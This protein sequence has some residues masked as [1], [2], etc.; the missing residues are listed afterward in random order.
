MTVNNAGSGTVSIRGGAVSSAFGD[1]VYNNQSG[2]VTITGGNITA[3]AGSG[4]AIYN[5]TANT[6]LGGTPNIR[7]RIGVN[8]GTLNVITTGADLFAPNEYDIFMLSFENLTRNMIV[9]R[10]GI[11]FLSNFELYGREDAILTVIDSNIVM[12]NE[13]T[14]KLYNVSVEGGSGNGNYPAGAIVTITAT[15]APNQ[16]FLNWMTTSPGV[17]FADANN[18]ITTFVMPANGVT[19]TVSYSTAVLSPERISPGVKPTEEAAVI[20]PVVALSG[21]FTAGPNIVNKNSGGVDIFRVGGW[22]GDGVLTVYDAVGNVVNRI[23]I[24]DVGAGLKPALTPAHS[25]DRRVVGSWDLR[26]A[27][28]GLVPTGTY[29]LRG[30]VVVG[31]KRERV[32]II[33]SVR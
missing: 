21:E 28:G 32:S 10:N 29:L 7:G 9:V 5:L 13:G 11:G 18:E 2:T 15:L 26:D 4:C 23:R 8:V 3:L 24:A 16:R 17:V 6:N 30:S 33:I 25:P 14:A 1:A 12:T 22:F 27:K 20:A 19:V 31:G